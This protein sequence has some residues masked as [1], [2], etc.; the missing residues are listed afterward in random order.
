ME[1]LEPEHYIRIR[2][3]RELTDTEVSQLTSIIESNIGDMLI[4]DEVIYHL[5]VHGDM[6]CYVF[7]IDQ[8][9]TVLNFGV[10]SGDEISMA[11]DEWLPLEDLWE[12][13][14]SLPEMTI[15]VTEEMTEQQI[16]ERATMTAK[17]LLH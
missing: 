14:T 3:S 1:V 2:I 13:E 17:T 15:E 6:H 4:N 12:I 8:D 7:E 5:N 9:L 10:K 16:F 11:I